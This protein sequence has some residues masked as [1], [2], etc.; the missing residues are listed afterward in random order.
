MISVFGNKS[1]FSDD[2]FMFQKEE[3]EWV[4]TRFSAQNAEM[5]MMLQR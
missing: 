2:I 5:R 3:V 1:F 4:A